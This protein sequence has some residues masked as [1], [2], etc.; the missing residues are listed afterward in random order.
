MADYPNTASSENSYKEI[1][2]AELKR[3]IDSGKSFYL[4]DA[5]PK[6]F[7]EGSVLPGAVFLPY[8]SDAKTIAK[9]LPSKDSIVVAYCASSKWPR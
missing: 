8:D 4:V 6:K 5:R 1:H 3:W 7:D 2:A 9:A